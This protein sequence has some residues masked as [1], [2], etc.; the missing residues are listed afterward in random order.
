MNNVQS[1]ALDQIRANPFQPRLSEDAEHVAAIA[2][3]I[4]RDGLLQIPSGRALTPDPSPEGRGEQT[5]QVVELAFGMTRLAAYRLLAAEH[6]EDERWA[7]MPVNIV[8]FDDR[9]MF[10]AAVTENIRRKDLNH[11]ERAQAMRRYMDEFGSTSAQV[12]ELFGVNESTV[13]GALRLLDL[14]EVAQ[15]A[16]REGSIS[17]GTARELLTVQKLA[18]TAVDE[19]VETLVSASTGSA[20][21]TPLSPQAMINKA[22]TQNSL[23]MWEWARWRDDH[24]RTA[25]RGLWALDEE[26]PEAFEFP[27]LEEFEAAY[28]GAAFF[29]VTIPPSPDADGSGTSPQGGEGKAESVQE[30]A[31]AVDVW[32]LV[33]EQFET[34][35][36]AQLPGIKYGSGA[37]SYLRENVPAA[38]EPVISTIEQLVQP[39]TCS[40]CPFH[41]VINK[42]HYCGMRACHARKVERWT[43][44]E[45]KAY[46]QESGFAIYDADVDGRSFDWLESTYQNSYADN[47]LVEEK[48]ADIRVKAK[49]TTG[50]SSH[51]YTDSYLFGLVVVGETNEARKEQARIEKEKR[52]EKEAQAAEERANRDPYHW[53]K[54]RAGYEIWRPIYQRMIWTLAGETHEDVLGELSFGVLD[55]LTDQVR[56]DAPEEIDAEDTVVLRQYLVAGLVHHA[57][58]VHSGE[59]DDDPMGWLDERVRALYQQWHVELPVD[60]GARVAAEGEEAAAQ[61]AV[62]YAE[63]EGVGD[64]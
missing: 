57:A 38:W 44:I 63:I 64:E 41:A 39:P 2:E 27:T 45:M 12:G 60:W 24:E 26:F 46:A 29:A 61:L 34:D 17:L 56:F 30:G 37:F 58:P 55:S 51:D 21:D 49:R 32:D 4:A 36:P 28:T 16:L 18:P 1:I 52:A 5:T 6:P 10:E 35:D 48:H 42:S 43:E 23:E 25:G 33:R 59:D 9:Q 8:D 40:S 22:I 31:K 47:K 3:S 54:K 11:I 53:E 7:S 19:T 62:K 15:E 13:R 14:P 20:T 50:Y